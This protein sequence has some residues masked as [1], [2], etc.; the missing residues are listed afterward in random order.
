MISP[1]RT[2]VWSAIPS[3]P[4]DLPQRDGDVSSSSADQRGC[5]WFSQQG[6][7]ARQPRKTGFQMLWPHDGFAELKSIS[8]LG[9]LPH[10]NAKSVAGA[11][12]SFTTMRMPTRSALPRRQKKEERKNYQ[13]AILEQATSIPF[14]ST[15]FQI[16]SPLNPNCS[17]CLIYD[18]R[19]HF[20]LAVSVMDD[21]P[22]YIA[23]AKVVCGKGQTKGENFS[24]E[25]IKKSLKFEQVGKNRGGNFTFSLVGERTAEYENM[26]AMIFEN[27]IPPFSGPLNSSLCL[28]GCVNSS[29]TPGRDP[30]SRQES[31]KRKRVEQKESS[32]TSLSELELDLAISDEINVLYF[33]DQSFSTSSDTT[34]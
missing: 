11:P 18:L 19:T 8:K 3:R 27:L 10:L 1:H 23:L 2:P 12:S 14:V 9:L 7:S 30:A 16:R 21:T 31:K 13:P 6:V 33:F 5:L 15:S 17:T 4:S 29:N 24:V 22:Q 26:K 28:V 20:T 25:N 34:C 32:Y